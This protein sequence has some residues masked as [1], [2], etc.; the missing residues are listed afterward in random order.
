M[1]QHRHS[2]AH[3]HAHWL[4]TAFR[5]TAF[6]G[7]AFRVNPAVLV[8][9]IC[10]LLASCGN[11]ANRM[12]MVVSPETGLMFGSVI[13]RNLVTDPS[14]FRNTGIK[15]RMRNTSGDRAFDLDGFRETLQRGYED[16]GYTR[17]DG[18]DFGLLMDINVIYSGQIR[19]NMAAEY[20][21]LGAVAGTSA[22][23]FQSES[24]F[25]VL[26][27]QLAGSAFGTV[28]GTFVTEDTYIVVA[29]VTFAVLKEYRSAKKRVTFS[30]SEKLKN[31]DDPDEDTEVLLRGFKK[32]FETSVA[33]F[34]G[35]TNTHQ[36]EI[37]EQVRRRMADIIADYI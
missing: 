6:R 18:E 25:T 27:A 26:G 23:L 37:A 35:G 22:A 20:G 11:T 28:A 12:G 16:K 21:V 30:R 19:R 32:T 7:T 15:V 17:P 33:V 34:A 36:H 29:E 1:I 13:E 3:P 14:F 31:I 9:P 5:G 10:L 2:T 24:S 8:I 4:R